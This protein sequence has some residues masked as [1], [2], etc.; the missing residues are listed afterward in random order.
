GDTQSVLA[1][2]RGIFA[3]H[4]IAGAVVI[5]SSAVTTGHDLQAGQR[6]AAFIAHETADRNA[7]FE[8]EGVL[9]RQCSA[10]GACLRIPRDLANG[11]VHVADRETEIVD[12]H[13]ASRHTHR[14]DAALVRPEA[15]F[16]RRFYSW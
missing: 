1:I 8:P 14:R 12:G 10:N 2:Q 3:S 5:G 16:I 4:R 6:L 13:S 15:P 7:A 11:I 9:L